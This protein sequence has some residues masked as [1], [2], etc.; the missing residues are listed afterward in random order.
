MLNITDKNHFYYSNVY[1][2]SDFL[3]FSS[4]IL[5]SVLDLFLRKILMMLSTL[6]WLQLLLMMCTMLIM[7]IMLLAVIGSS[8]NPGRQHMQFLQL[9]QVL[10]DGAGTILSVAH[11]QL[12]ASERRLYATI[13]DV[14][15]TSIL[16]A[17]FSLKTNNYSML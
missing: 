2:F 4:S 13:V 3:F 11:I 6:T 1:F 7:M 14:E 5:N 16:F 10:R 17:V 12:S 9:V 8:Q 15:R